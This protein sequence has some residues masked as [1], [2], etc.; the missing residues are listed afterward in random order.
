MGKNRNLAEHAT[1]NGSHFRDVIQHWTIK[2]LLFQLPLSPE[3]HRSAFGGARRTALP[4]KS[5][6]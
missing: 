3:R 4:R 6:I 1:P 2:Y 5:R